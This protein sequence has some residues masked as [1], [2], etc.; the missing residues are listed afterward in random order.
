[1]RR[2]ILQLEVD[3]GQKSGFG[4][5]CKTCEVPVGYNNA[6]Q[7]SGLTQ[8]APDQWNSARFL[9]VCVAWSWFRSQSS[10]NHIPKHFSRTI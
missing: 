2:D 4:I 7:K 3:A 5:M 1:M 10:T 6:P 8:R 9:A